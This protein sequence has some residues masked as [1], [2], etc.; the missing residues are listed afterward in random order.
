MSFPFDNSDS[1]IHE[2]SICIRSFDL[3]NDECPLLEHAFL[4]DIY[5]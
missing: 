5:C 4:L 3:P 1:L 2:I